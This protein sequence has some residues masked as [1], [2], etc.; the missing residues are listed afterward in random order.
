MKHGSKVRRPAKCPTTLY[1]PL[2]VFR[3][4]YSVSTGVFACRAGS[5]TQQVAAKYNAMQRPYITAAERSK[6]PRFAARGVWSH[7]FCGMLSRTVS[8]TPFKV[9]EQES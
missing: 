4:I 6:P 2:P 1:V 9:E 8:P 7:F 5:E 3:V